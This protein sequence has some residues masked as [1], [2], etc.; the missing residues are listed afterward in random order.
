MSIIKTI[1]LGSTTVA[2]LMANSV[3]AQESD[4]NYVID[5]VLVT[6]QKRESSLQT[7]PLSVSV[8]TGDELEA[9]GISTIEEF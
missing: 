5:E 1:L 6:A 7:T 2:L 9:I 3:G 8:L 4:D